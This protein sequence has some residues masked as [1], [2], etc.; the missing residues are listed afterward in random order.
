M[1]Y[2]TR[3][4]LE[5]EYPTEMSRRLYELAIRAET[6]SYD[7]SLGDLMDDQTDTIKWYD[8][9]KEMIAFSLK[10][11]NVLF[12]M[13]GVGEEHPDVWRAWI[14]NGRS[15]ST[16][17]TFTFETPKLEVVLPL[18]EDVEQIQ[19]N[20]IAEERAKLMKALETLKEIEG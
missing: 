15:V 5:V 20:K 7:Y 1:G 19:R 4:T 8:W 17:A 13:T 18:R 10:Y 16:K 9:E 6:T 14:R 2:Y 3:Y 12:V 11:P